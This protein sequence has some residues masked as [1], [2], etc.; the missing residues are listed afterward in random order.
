[1]NSARITPVPHAPAIDGEF[2]R[3]GNNPDL[4]ELGDPA[5]QIVDHA[6]FPSDDG[7]WHLWACV[8]GT[9]IGRLLY[10]WEGENI[11]QPNWTPQG[12][13]MRAEASYGE[14]LNDWSGEE[15][16]QA[17]HVIQAE[18]KHW[19]FFGGHNTEL[20]T[21][22]ICLATSPD[23]R[24]F[25]RYRNTQ[26]Y[27]RV[28]VGPGEAR[29]PMVI[30]VGDLYH[31]YYTGH[32]TGRF[33]PC[34]VYCRTSPDLLQWSDYREVSWGGHASG[35]HRWSSE[36]PFVVYLDGYYY[37]F[38]TSEYRAPARTHVYRS[39]DPLDFG[40]GTD[41][42]WVTS[43]RVAAPE[44]MQVGDQFYISTVEDLTGGVQVARLKWQ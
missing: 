18:G 42:K 39:T 24:A 38:R 7:R 9:T 20:G 6:I 31:C 25:A 41:E 16:I 17:P 15:W 22:Q 35:N 26:G 21:C 4:G 2:W 44:V 5:Q 12:V 30:R 32:D 14:S 40:L 13:A 19:M 27:S 36:C 11:E 23:G 10:A 33:K 37:L 28:F 3:I 29:D 8:R 43:L 34:K 1:M